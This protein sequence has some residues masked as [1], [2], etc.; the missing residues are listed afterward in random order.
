MKSEKIIKCWRICYLYLFDDNGSEVRN[1]F[2]FYQDNK[3]VY[4]C[5]KIFWRF[6][7]IYDISY[8]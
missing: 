1:K 7:W 2:T 6:Y 8:L 3:A 4:D 5:Q